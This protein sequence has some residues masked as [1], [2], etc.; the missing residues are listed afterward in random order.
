MT[1]TDFTVKAKALASEGAQLAKDWDYA[2]S[3][4]GE[5]IQQLGIF[6]DPELFEI[7]ETL[8]KRSRELA[9]KVAAL[10]DVA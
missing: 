2:W 10:T 9:L 4:E 7:I 1:M 3:E 5:N 6:I 8:Y